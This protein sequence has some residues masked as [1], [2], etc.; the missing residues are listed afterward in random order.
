[1][2]YIKYFRFISLK[3]CCSDVGKM[4]DLDRTADKALFTVPQIFC[5]KIEGFPG[6]KF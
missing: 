6:R 5:R 4:F 1:M 3:D 2:I